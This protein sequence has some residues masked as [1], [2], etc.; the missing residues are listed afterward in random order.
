MP[1]RERPADV[2]RS[3]HW[4]RIAVNEHTDE[5]ND[6]IKNA[7]G[8][9]SAE[10]IDWRSPL[11]SDGYAEYY[12]SEF[13]TQLGIEN[14]RV[15]LIRFWPSSGPRWDGLARTDT[16]KVTLVEAKAHVGEMISHTRD[17]PE[18]LSK[19]R[20]AI[21]RT[22]AAFGAADKFDWESP[23]YQYANRL[24]HLYF[25][26]ELNGLD[27]YLLFV[28]FADAPDVPSAERCTFHQWEGAIRLVEKA[29]GLGSHPFRAYIKSLILPVP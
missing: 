20:A 26:R 23:F 27:A 5:L 19:I 2:E 29:L 18:S 17:S 28:Y 6:A 13:L 22:K 11:K 25:L 7:F 21:E 24:A 8:W 14:L 15:P 1:R 9:P 10:R 12:D 4:L 16:G 3:E